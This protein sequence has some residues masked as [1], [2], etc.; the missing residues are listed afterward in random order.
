[1]SWIDQVFN[2]AAL[3]KKR[4]FFNAATNSENCHCGFGRKAF[5]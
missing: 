2:Y 1:M 3:K 4:I 5:G